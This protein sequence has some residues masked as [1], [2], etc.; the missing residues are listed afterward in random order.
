MRILTLKDE[1][2][3]ALEKIDISAIPLIPI[4]ISTDHILKSVVLVHPETDQQS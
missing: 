2:L 4:N 1:E 3:D